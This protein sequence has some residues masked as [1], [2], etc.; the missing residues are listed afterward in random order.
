[1]KN[2]SISSSSQKENCPTIEKCKQYQLSVS[3][4]PRTI[5]GALRHREQSEAI[6]TR[7]L[8]SRLMP[9]EWSHR[10]LVELAP[11][12]CRPVSRPSRRARAEGHDLGSSDW[13]RSGCR[14]P[15][16]R[17]ESRGGVEGARRP[18]GHG[19]LGAAERGLDRVHRTGSRRT[20]RLRGEFPAAPHR[21]QRSDTTG[22]RR[23]GA[24]GAQPTTCNPGTRPIGS[25]SRLP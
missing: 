11:W 10:H 20:G 18:D 16:L 5:C 21:G 15:R 12:P 14:E 9:D 25:C 13:P 3:L 24:Q 22:L 19:Q 1:M 2:H 8:Q 4:A 17:H 6:Q 7:G 23:Q